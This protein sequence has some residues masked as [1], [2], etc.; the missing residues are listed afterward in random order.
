[1]RTRIK[2]CGCAAWADVDQAIAAGADAAGMIFA[3]SPRRI[4]WDAAA[5]IAERI[6]SRIIPAGVFVNPSREEIARA[7]A[8]FPEMI[9]QLSGDE[10]PEFVAGIEG[11]VIK[12]IHVDGDEDLGDLEASCNRYKSALAMFDTKSADAFGGTGRAFDWTKIAQIARSRPVVVA[13]GL[14]P[15]NV[16]ACVRTVRPAWLDVRSG[17]ETSGRKDAGKMQRFID[18]VRKSDAA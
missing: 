8:L 6:G 18:A 7:R 12:A 9:V 14:T 15:E 5:E 11:A 4:D 2:F 13:G 17:I 16:G 10:T 3:D 1:M